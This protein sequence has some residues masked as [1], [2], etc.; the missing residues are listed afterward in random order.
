MHLKVRWVFVVNGCKFR[1]IG[2]GDDQVHG[3]QVA[4]AFLDNI[5]TFLNRW[6]PPI[7]I[8]SFDKI[9]NLFRTYPAC[10]ANTHTAQFAVENKCPL[11]VNKRH[12]VFNPDAL[13]TKSTAGMGQQQR[14][15]SEL[16]E[17]IRQ[18]L[19]KRTPSRALDTR[20]FRAQGQRTVQDV[21]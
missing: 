5:D 17:V 2:A 12:V 20:C 13:I 3:S 14:C 8:E 7:M 6:Q 9:E 4:R 19:A 15:A 18:R 11:A 10:L 21:S 16:C 1:R